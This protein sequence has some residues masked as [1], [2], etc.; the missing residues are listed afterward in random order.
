MVSQTLDDFPVAARLDRTERGKATMSNESKR[1]PRGAWAVATALA[2][3][4]I[5]ATQAPA[6]TVIYDSTGFESPT[7][8]TGAL[9]SYWGPPP[10]PPGPG[11]QNGWLTTDVTQALSGPA[12]GAGQ[13]VNVNAFAGTQAFRIDGTKL[14]NDPQFFAS[15]FWFRS[16]AVGA[17]S[18]VASGTPFVTVS[19][20]QRVDTTGITVGDMPFVGVY[21]DGYTGTGTQLGIT[22]VFRNVNGGVTVLGPNPG[23]AANSF[24]AYNTA[25]N[26][27]SANTYHN[28][29][30][31][32]NF[33][34]TGTNPQSVAVT[35]D[36]TALSF[37]PANGGSAVA[38]VPFKNSNVA[39]TTTVGIAEYGFQASFNT[40]VTTTTNNAFFDNFL[41]TRAA[42]PEPASILLLCGGVA[43]AGWQFRRRKVSA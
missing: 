33:N 3:A 6:Q 28:L 39:G 5:A 32:L 13:I 16:A 11:G 31:T 26:I 1:A 19:T 14:F 29:Q 40:Q 37:T 18:P 43:A 25:D 12:G 38:T 2:V 10:N 20:R 23:Q 27:W 4:L 8:A 41:V 30:V 17:I 22:N 9:A 7:F 42:V 15:T 24:Q 34:T 36:G 21:L 35:L